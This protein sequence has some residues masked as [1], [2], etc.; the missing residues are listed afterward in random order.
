MC[1]RYFPFFKRK[2][3]IFEKLMICILYKM[4]V[5]TRR[6][7]F[8]LLQLPSNVTWVVF[9]DLLQLPSNVTWVV[10][11]EYLFCLIIYL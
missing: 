11:V 8:Y 6:F 1:S 10:F 9:V 4:R 3:M 5:R 7:Y 2:I